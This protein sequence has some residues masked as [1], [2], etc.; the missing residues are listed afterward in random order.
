[1]MKS[2]IIAPVKS[3]RI[4]GIGFE[5]WLT[6]SPEY[7]IAS[8]RTVANAA[9]NPKNASLK[10]RFVETLFTLESFFLISFFGFSVK[11][12]N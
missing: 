10:N 11:N 12:S 5:I 3:P 2:W 1:M 7:A 9:R 8:S 6:N 4:I